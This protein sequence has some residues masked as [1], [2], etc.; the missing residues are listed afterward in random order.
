M[1]T[2]QALR[3]IEREYSHTSGENQYTPY[4]WHDT[5][6]YVELNGTAVLNAAVYANMAVATEVA[7]VLYI[8]P[9]AVSY[10]FPMMANTLD[11]N[12]F[13]AQLCEQFRK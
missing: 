8:V 2:A 13:I 10:Q 7:F 12:L 1:T 4:G 6:A 3:E 11:G 9:G 5:H